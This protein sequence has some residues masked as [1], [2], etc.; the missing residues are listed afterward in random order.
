[1]IT[2]NYSC[3]SSSSKKAQVLGL[4]RRGRTQGSLGLYFTRRGP[5]H[6]SEQGVDCRARRPQISRLFIQW[7]SRGAMNAIP[8]TCQP[9]ADQLDQLR[10][11][12]AGATIDPAGSSAEKAADKRR[13][14][15][16]QEWDPVS[17]RPVASLP[18]Q[19]TSYFNSADTP[20]R[21]VHCRYRASAMPP[22]LLGR[23]GWSSGAAG[24]GQAHGGACIRGR[25][26]RP[27]R[28]R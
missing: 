11:E 7:R 2:T 18:P 27:S 3:R 26:C 16:S 10:K 22:R 14:N 4:R 9:L 19:S 24:G 8:P 12:L 5:R 13:I 23:R 6:S 25:R 17:H 21:A 15:S 28:A 20:S 1:M